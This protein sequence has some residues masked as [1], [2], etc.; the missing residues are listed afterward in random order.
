MRDTIAI[1]ATARELVQ[2][3]MALPWRAVNKMVHSDPVSSNHAVFC[4]RTPIWDHKGAYSSV[5][6]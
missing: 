5:A 3:G 2:V 4:I 1:H 6:I